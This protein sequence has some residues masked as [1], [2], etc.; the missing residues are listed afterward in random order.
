MAKV[1]YNFSLSGNLGIKTD[2]P[3]DNRLVVD[4]KSDLIDIDTWENYQYIGMIVSVVN[5]NIMDNNGI[6]VFMGNSKADV[7]NIESWY[8]LDNQSPVWLE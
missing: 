2:K 6:Y 3:I 8:K 7:V 1:E 5:D 4:N